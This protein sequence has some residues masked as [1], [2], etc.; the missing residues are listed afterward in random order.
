MPHLLNMQV[1]YYLIFTDEDDG[2]IEILCSD[3]KEIYPN[4]ENVDDYHISI[5]KTFVLRHHWIEPF[6]KTVK[7]NIENIEK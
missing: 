2:L 1:L 7:E 3:I 6:V 5:T 4:L